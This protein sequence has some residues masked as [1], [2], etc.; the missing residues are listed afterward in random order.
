MG[1]RD[2]MIRRLQEDGLWDH[3]TGRQQKRFSSLSDDQA[4]QIMIFDDR[5]DMG[6]MRTIEFFGLNS[7]VQMIALFKGALVQTDGEAAGRLS[8]TGK[9][10]AQFLLALRESG[11][12]PDE[13]KEG[14]AD[15]SP[16]VM[17]AL[18]AAH[19]SKPE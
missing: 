7:L 18:L 13:I 3:L 2:D 8:E 19:Q 5:W 15:L 1:Y 6:D 14:L 4:R 10:L 9:L 11:L 17:A 16:L 12:S